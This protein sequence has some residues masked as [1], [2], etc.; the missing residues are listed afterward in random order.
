MNYMRN[1]EQKKNYSNWITIP[2]LIIILIGFLLFTSVIIPKDKKD[3]VLINFKTAANSKVGNEVLAKIGDKNITV[4]EF[5]SSYEFGPAFPKRIKNSKKHFLDYM[6]NE[7]LIA[8]KGYSQNIDD[9]TE[10][11]DLLNAI[12][13]DLSTEEMFKDDILK[14]IKVKKSELNKA[15][16]E[17]QI[18]CNVRWLYSPDNKIIWAFQSNLNKGVSFDSLFNLQINDSVFADQRSMEMDK[19]KLK[20]RNPELS[21]IID[22]MKIG[23]ITKPVKEGDGW[24]IFKLDDIWK[25]EVTTQSELGEEKADAEEAIK[26]EKMDGKSD[27]YVN[28]LL[29]SEMPVIKG[30][31]FA[32][33]RS[34]LGRYELP[35]EKY[36]DWKLEERL[37]EQVNKL[38][39]KNNDYGK[40][41]LITLKDTL[42]NIH[43]FINWYRTRSQFIKLDKETFNKFSASIESNIWQ[44]VRDNLLMKRAY[45]RGYQEKESVTQQLKWWKDKIVYAV[46]RDK[47]INSIKLNS[48]ESKT[49]SLPKPDEKKDAEITKKILHEVLALKQKY[50]I[51]IN[52]KLLEKIYVEDSNEPKAID[53]YI[54]KKGGIFPHPAF[55]TIDMLWQ[56]W[57]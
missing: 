57:Q 30:E 31:A 38:N 29:K 22:S 13:G 27:I 11:K 45:A 8:L 52:E 48:S 36:N 28:N 7:K 53:I 37:Y 47:I 18:N 2:R 15:A 12:K 49:N 32:I 51:E 42:L 54:V 14:N 33:L 23:G 26:K 50:K 56:S 35:K 17:K 5:L 21:G 19:F 40:L 46:T 34:Y 20:I 16:A 39:I 9:S 43:D 10:V 1:F 6:I 25:D 55:P 4:R 41:T 44:M 3:S 24:Y